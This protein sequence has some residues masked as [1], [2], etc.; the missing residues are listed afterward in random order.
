VLAAGCGYDRRMRAEIIFYAL[1]EHGSE[2]LDGLERQ[3][4]QKSEQLQGRGRRYRVSG[5]QGG[6]DA[7]D[8]TLDTIAPDWREHLTRTGM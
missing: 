2:I 5:P 3:T 8:A 4:G 7:F 6:L 1:D